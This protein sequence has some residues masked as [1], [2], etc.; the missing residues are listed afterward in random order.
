MDISN[1]Q[2]AGF[3]E[4]EA[5]VYLANLELGESSISRI[6]QKSGIKRTTTYLAVES[7]KEKGLLTSLRKKKKT[8]FYAEDPRKIQELVNERK[9]N[10]EHIMPE[11]LSIANFIDKKP[12]IR[13]FE[14]KEGLKEIFKDT[15]NYPNQEIL[16]WFPRTFEK[17]IDEYYVPKRIAK[18]IWIRA[19]MPDTEKSRQFILSDLAQLR[20]SKL[21]SDN[22]FKVS[23]EISLYGKNKI[24]IMS[25]EEEI[26]LII[27]SQ[28]IFESLKSIFEIMWD[29]LPEIKIN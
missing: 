3:T 25:F 7:L 19:L 22:K 1:L 5:K 11:L 17:F 4:N 20:Q 9:N 14:G 12:Q 6:A 29:S 27:E 13:Y 21:V 8:F 26:G 28:K 15:L 23:V 10:I 16:A 18:K 2:S 24:G